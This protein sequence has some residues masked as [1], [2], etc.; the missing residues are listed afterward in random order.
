[1][2]LLFTYYIFSPRLHILTF[3]LPSCIA[4][5]W[6]AMMHFGSPLCGGGQGTLPP[7]LPSWF[8]LRDAL[9]AASLQHPVGAAAVSVM[10]VVGSGHTMLLP[11]SWLLQ[12]R[13][14][15]LQGMHAACLHSGFVVITE[16]AQSENSVSNKVL[17]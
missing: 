11:D 10:L 7:L 12:N 14:S 16:K 15:V 4:A 6:L 3:C 5:V 9:R 1:M 17:V 13:N 8:P 2:S